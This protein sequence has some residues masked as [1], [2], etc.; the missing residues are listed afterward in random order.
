MEGLY[1]RLYDPA[2]SG[3]PEVERSLDDEVVASMLE[4]LARAILA[5]LF[6]RD[7]LHTQRT[8]AWMGRLRTFCAAL[9]FRMRHDFLITGQD[10]KIILGGGVLPGGS[11]G[12][13][14]KK[15]ARPARSR[16]T[17]HCDRAEA[18]EG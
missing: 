1:A 17:S 15:D 10:H 5:E 7:W 8:P 2:R 3:S 6:S 14:S 18:C 16:K 12:A 11:I 4:G 9:S 13:L